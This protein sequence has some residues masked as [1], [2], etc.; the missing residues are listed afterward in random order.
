MS[1]IS[2]ESLGLNGHL[3]YVQQL[4]MQY[5][6]MIYEAQ[7]EP[8]YTKAGRKHAKSCFMVIRPGR[9]LSLS[10]TLMPN[11]DAGSGLMK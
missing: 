5:H 9:I 2:W 8:G 11:L 4:D 3:K 1:R 10:S 7:K 6:A